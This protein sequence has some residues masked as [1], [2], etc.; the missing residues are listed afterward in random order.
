[1]AQLKDLIVNGASRLIGD[2]FVNKIQTTT[3]NAPTSSGGT[4]YGPGTSGQVLKSNGTSVYWGTDSNSVTGVKGNSESSYR[5]GNV[6]I[7]AANI[8]LGNVENT[9]LSTW[10]GSSNIT[11]IGTLSSG[12]VPWARLSNVPAGATKEGTVTK[13]I[14]GTGLSIGSTSGGNFTT[15]GTINHTNSVTAQTT[16]AVYPIKIDAQGHISAYGSA[17]TIP[18]IATN[19]PLMDL[20]NGSIGSSSKYAKEDHVHP[21]DTSRAAAGLGISSASVGQ[22]VKISSVD[23]SGVPT[24]YTSGTASSGMVITLTLSGGVYTADKT[25]DEISAALSSGIDCCVVYNSTQYPFISKRE[26][27]VGFYFD[28]C[29]I[30]V[31][32]NYTRKEGFT[33]FR[34]NQNNTKVDTCYDNNPNPNVPDP[35]APSVILELVQNDDDPPNWVINDSPIEDIEFCFNGEGTWTPIIIL[36]KHVVD[37]EN[38]Y[39]PINGDTEN[40]YLSKL[41]TTYEPTI[42]GGFEEYIITGYLVFQA[43]VND[44]G[45]KKIKTITVS[46]EF[47]QWDYLANATITFSEEVVDTTHYYCS[48]TLSSTG[49]YR[50]LHVANPT[51][52]ISR[53]IDLTITRNYV[54]AN[55]ESHCIKYI[56]NYNSHSFNNEVSKSNTILVDKVRY[57]TDSNYGYVDIHYAGTSANK[58]AVDFECYAD[59]GLKQSCAA[60]SLQSVA[61]APSGETVVTT[62]NFVA[63]TQ[64]SGSVAGSY[65]TIYYNRK[66]D[67]CSIYGDVTGVPTGSWTTLATGLPAPAITQFFIAQNGSSNDFVM[68]QLNTSGTLKFYGRDSYSSGYPTQTYICN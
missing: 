29:I 6:N 39:P 10:A 53:I 52:S 66:G 12:T 64:I 2:A 37:F 43:I 9:K 20:G 28:F 15:S 18:Q 63:S 16:Q 41:Y 59:I 45:I 4:T 48:A 36:R 1:M 14:A 38:Y 51:G 34:D 68:C 25:Y 22:V 17:V 24:A 65:G 55:N 30:N 7:T 8:G 50:V 62:Y 42:I 57:T 54:N 3:I 47:Y 67:V 13:V 11:T 32:Q 58:I 5:T 61:D 56:G 49:W 21:T 31:S 26:S 35:L 60:E 44:N 27:S 33:I 46:E 19:T 23:S 40:Y